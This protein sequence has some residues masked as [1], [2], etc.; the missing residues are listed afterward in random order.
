MVEPHDAAHLSF[1][2]CLWVIDW[3]VVGKTA[4]LPIPFPNNI[5]LRLRELVHV[6]TQIYFCTSICYYAQ[7]QKN[8]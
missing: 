8:R 3:V 4:V 1:G 7:S 6:E 5:L 2:H